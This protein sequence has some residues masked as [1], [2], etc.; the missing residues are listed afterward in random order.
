MDKSRIFNP[1]D[2][3]RIYIRENRE[4]ENIPVAAIGVAMTSRTAGTERL[5][6]PGSE[7]LWL[8]IE[9]SETP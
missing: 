5:E 7:G 2:R 6:A 9:H 4:S 1:L 3:H 8:E